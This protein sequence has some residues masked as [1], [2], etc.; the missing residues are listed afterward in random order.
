MPW[1]SCSLTVL[2]LV[3]LP[4]RTDDWPGFLAG[5]RGGQTGLPDRWSK[6]ENIAWK[7]EVPGR[8][9]SSPVVHGDRIFLT[10]VVSE[11]KPRDPKK[12][13][14]IN[15]LQGTTPPGEHRWL[16]LCLDARTGKTLWQQEAHKG[17]APG[18]VHIKNSYASETPV[19]DSER[20]YALFG[21]LGVFCFSHD[22]K[23]LWKTPLESRKTRFGWGPAAS[24]ALHRDRLFVVCDNEEA[25]CMRALDDRTGKDLGRVERD[26]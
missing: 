19:A 14:Y 22:G 8:G 15:D 16:V 23:P 2:L 13:L 24:P 6:T 10:T 3:A 18:T 12:G 20:V 25:S 11:T 1:M 7:V 5:N 4:A 26:E 21:N 9:W 17:K